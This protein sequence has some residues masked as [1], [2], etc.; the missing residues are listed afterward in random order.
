VR[1]APAWL[2]GYRREWAARDLLAGL[3]VWSVVVPQAAAYA[4]IAGLPPSAG[5]AAAP[6]A[7]IAYALVGTSRSLVVSAT[8]A[9]S[10]LSAA[11]VGPLAHGDVKKF[12]ALSAAAAI[13][14]GVVVAAGGVFR[15]GGVMDLVSKP[16]MTG[17]LFGLGL[18]VAI[19]QLPKLFG[20]PAGSGHFFQQLWDLVTNLDQADWW[21]FGTGAIS[22]VALVALRRFAR[23]VPGMLIVLA[24]AIVL[25]KALDLK[26]HGVDVIGKLPS[27]YPDPAI[28]DVSWG[29]ILNLLGVAFGVLIVSAEAVSVGRTLAAQ[30]GYRVDVNRDLVA[31]GAANAAAGFSSGFIQS[32]G[33]SQTIAA[34]EAGGKTQLTS[35]IAAVLIVFTGVFLAFVFEDLPQATLGAIVIVAIAGFWRVDEIRRFATLRRSAVL[36]SLIALVGVLLMGILPGLILA[37][38]LSLAFLIQRLSRP[39][40]APVGR[41]PAT[42]EWGRIDLHPGWEPPPGV[43]AARVEGLLFYANANT[44][45]ERLLAMARSTDPPPR[46]LV[47]DVAESPGFDVETLD[48]LTDLVGRLGADGIELRLANV[49]EHGRELLRR[50]GLLPRLQVSRSLDEAAVLRTDTTSPSPLH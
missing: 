25:S 8:T 11:A 40:V 21:T 46:A 29:D 49:R 28:P 41:D 10:A 17:F 5:L 24:G 33:A 31:L 32:G 39:Q 37:A 34:E 9:T 12:A 13:V 48:M 44:V 30:Q 36:L 42:G 6:V 2:T 19:G 35:V 14:T 3:L 27:A 45:Q 26:S 20:V 16:V 15:L 47:L 22:L 18:T 38:G 50:R 7:M 4:Q 1:I 23:N 43:V